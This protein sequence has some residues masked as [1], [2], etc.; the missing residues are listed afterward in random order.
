[1][2]IND[3]NAGFYASLPWLALTVLM[4]WAIQ[5]ILAYTP[6]T[7]TRFTIV[8][9]L[10]AVGIRGIMKTLE[11]WQDWF[12]EARDTFPTLSRASMSSWAFQ[13]VG[14]AIVMAI[15][16]GVTASTVLAILLGFPWRLG[17]ALGIIAAFFCGV[18]SYLALYSPPPPDRPGPTQIN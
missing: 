6:S 9:L 18:G 4:A 3:K 1:M 15:I 17:T 12:R 10:G 5:A 13:N 2:E 16:A 8:L 14:V 7:P 11:H